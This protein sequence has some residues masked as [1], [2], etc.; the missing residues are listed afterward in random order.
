MQ[1]ADKIQLQST[2]LRRGKQYD[3]QW[4]PMDLTTK[5]VCAARG[6][7]AVLMVDAPL[8]PEQP[9]VEVYS[10][11][12]ALIKRFWRGHA[13]VLAGMGWSSQEEI[14][15]ITEEGV[16]HV[17][18]LFGEQAPGPQPSLLK[19]D[20]GRRVIAC[21]VLGDGCVLLTNEFELVRW[22]TVNNSLESLGGVEDLLAAVSYTHLTLP[23]KRIV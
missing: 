22:E 7:G 9:M 11:S 17:F 21:E 18:S 20:C 23:T 10:G 19:G 14:V 13:G 6:A 15:C 4:E 2:T 1:E 5:S 16:V 12:G 8:N 3:M